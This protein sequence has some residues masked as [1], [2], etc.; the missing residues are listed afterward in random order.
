MEAKDIIHPEDAKAIK[1]IK[2]IPGLEKAI[3]CFMKF[4]FEQYDTGRC[5]ELPGIVS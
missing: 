2:G 3:A 4:G 5:L 1:A